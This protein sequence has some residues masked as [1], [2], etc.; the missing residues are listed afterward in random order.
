MDSL[1]STAPAAPETMSEAC[2]GTSLAFVDLWPDCE[3]QFS[4]PGNVKT[5]IQEL[6]NFSIGLLVDQH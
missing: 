4:K 5:D 3:F 1:Q 6:L 2:R